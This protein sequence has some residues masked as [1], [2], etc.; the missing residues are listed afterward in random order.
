MGAG[1]FALVAM[2]DVGASIGRM[3]AAGA[4]IENA[5]K[6]AMVQVAYMCYEA[7]IDYCRG[8]VYMD[9][10]G[11]DY[12]FTGILLHSHYL[13][14]VGN[15]GSESLANALDVSPIEGTQAQSEWAQIGFGVQ[16][17]DF[18]GVTPSSTVAYI[19]GNNADQGEGGYAPFV[20]DGTWKMHP[21]PW[22]EKA[23]MATYQPATDV[24]DNGVKD[25]VVGPFR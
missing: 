14:P 12:V 17:S 18:G 25:A 7:C 1:Q 8:I 11:D 16:A 23:M 22:M 2:E 3:K 13:K 19:I 20:H 6:K 10:I 4:G 5:M 15:I 21:R 9:A 24:L